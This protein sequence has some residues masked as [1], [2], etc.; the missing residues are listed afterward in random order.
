MK[1]VKNQTALW[2]LS[3]QLA[4]LITFD[5]VRAK[6]QP[7][8]NAQNAGKWGADMDATLRVIIQSVCG[9]RDLTSSQLPGKGCAVQTCWF[10]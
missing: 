3:L 6:Q 7:T 2:F 4:A 5:T 8:M 9:S 10:N 1:Q